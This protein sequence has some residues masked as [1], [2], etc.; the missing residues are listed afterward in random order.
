VRGNFVVVTPPAIEPLTVA[1]VVRHLG[2][3]ST[4]IGEPAPSA[5]TV[6]LAGIA[7]NVDN[8][9]HRY[10]VTFVTAA[11]E[12]E[13]GTVSS[14]ITVADKAVSGKVTV[15]A[16][17]LGSSSVTSRKIYR[18]AAGGST[19]LLV[20]TIAD[21]TTT[22]YTDNIAD[23]ALGAGAPSTNTTEDA[24]IT[25]KIASVRSHV[26][27]R[28]ARALITQ[29]LA[30]KM[31]CFPG[32]DVI[33]L[34]RPNLLTVSS[35]AYIDAN[36]DTQT[37]S[38]DDYSVDVANLP[39]RIILGYGKSWP[40]TRGERNSVTITYTAGY[41]SARSSVPSDIRSAMKLLISDLFENRES[42]IVGMIRN[43]NPT[44]DNLLAL[45]EFKEAG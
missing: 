39:G 9:V 4:G 26:E 33:E 11:G 36:G 32:C 18:T 34:P 31:D 44:V 8:G 20:A 23:S 19:Y 3:P 5:P 25:E 27:K 28:L 42:Q 17:P 13:A 14:A 21:N 2:L 7:G 15:S 43:D 38:T 37:M 24:D 40:S 16:I 29:T 1:E 12:T 35:I 22:S 41:G 6:A 30:L 10:L 45:H